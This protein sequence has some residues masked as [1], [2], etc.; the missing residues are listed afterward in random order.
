MVIDYSPLFKGIS[1]ILVILCICVVGVCACVQMANNAKGFENNIDWAV[2]G[3]CALIV[4]PLS[5]IA[6]YLW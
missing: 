2:W 6:Y 4:C 3:A 1:V 5:A